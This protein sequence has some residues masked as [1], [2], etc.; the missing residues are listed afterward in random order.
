MLGQTGMPLALVA[1]GM[2]LAEYDLRARWGE[3]QH[4]RPQARRPCRSACWAGPTDR[5][6]SALETMVIVLFR[7]IGL[8][9]NV[10]LMARQFKAVRSRHRRRADPD[11]GRLSDDD[12]AA[13]GGRRPRGRSAAALTRAGRASGLRLLTRAVQNNPVVTSEGTPRSAA[14]GT[15]QTPD[16]QS[17]TPV[18]VALRPRGVTSLRPACGW[19]FLFHESLDLPQHGDVVRDDRR[20]FGWR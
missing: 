18:L 1:L 13:A 8:G 12:A 7:S 6:A 16:R 20:C 14:D 9:A 17:A 5:P 3:R 10:F 2:S 4:C 11:H 19:R 15:P